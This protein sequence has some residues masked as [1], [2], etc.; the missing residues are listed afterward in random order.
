MD[1]GN[2]EIPTWEE[3]SQRVEEGQASPL[4]TFIANNEPTGQDDEQQFRKQLLA[5]VRALFQEV[6]EDAEEIY[7]RLTA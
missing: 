5:L 7:A 1:P 2:I 6:E 3:A 4:D